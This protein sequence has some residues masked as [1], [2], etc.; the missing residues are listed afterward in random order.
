MFQALN[1][2]HQEV[3]SIDAASGIILSVS[4]HSVHRLR[5]QFSLN[6]CTERPL[7]ERTIT[8]AA[9]MQLAS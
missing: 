2:L 8:D 1:A 6:L 9:S 4:G 3:N 7:T 5:E